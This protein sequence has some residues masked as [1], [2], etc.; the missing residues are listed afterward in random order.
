MNGQDKKIDDP[1][2][3]IKYADIPVQ[4]YVNY[5]A[6]AR[7]NDRWVEENMVRIDDEKVEADHAIF[8]EKERIEEEVRGIQEARKGTQAQ[9]PKKEKKEKKAKKSRDG[10]SQKDR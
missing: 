5:M 4:Y 1:E 3:N 7:R 9:D 8:V 6:E 2:D 10:G